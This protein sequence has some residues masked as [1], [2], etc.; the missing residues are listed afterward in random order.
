MRVDGAG[1]Q[2]YVATVEDQPV[3]DYLADDQPVPGRVLVETGELVAGSMARSAA[4]ILFDP[5]S[6]RVQ[7]DPRVGWCL[8]EA[9]QAA[10]PLVPL[11]ERARV[12]GALAFAVELT[13][14][15]ASQGRTA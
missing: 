14:T 12:G 6:S 10:S 4:A 7:L 5:S 8:R 2:E 15:R 1:V 9:A 13:V 11:R 3:R